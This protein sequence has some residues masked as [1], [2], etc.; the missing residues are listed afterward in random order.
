VVRA[1]HDRR[2]ARA[3]PAPRRP[4]RAAWAV[5]EGA[6]PPAFE[7]TLGR[8]EPFGSTAFSVVV[9]CEPLVTWVKAHRADVLAAAVAKPERRPPS[10]HVTVA[11]ARRGRAAFAAWAAGQP[12]VDVTLTLD[13]VALYTRAESGA[14][15]YQKVERR[16]L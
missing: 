3:G 5:L 12:R 4:A 7:A 6:S 9:E 2:A 15:H 10:P 11:W 13:E 1:A 8:V 14:A 16:Q